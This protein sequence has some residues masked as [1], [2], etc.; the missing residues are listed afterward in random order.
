MSNPSRSRQPTRSR[1]ADIAGPTSPPNAR[2]S[3]ERRAGVAVGVEERA[4]GRVLGDRGDQALELTRRARRDGRRAAQHRE[5]DR[6]AAT[7][8]QRP[9]CASRSPTGSIADPVKRMCWKIICEWCSRQRVRYATS[10]SSDSASASTACSSRCVLIAAGLNVSSHSFSCSRQTLC[11]QTSSARA[12]RCGISS[13]GAGR[14]KWYAKPLTYCRLQRVE[15]SAV[16]RHELVRAPA[17]R[18]GMHLRPVPRHRTREMHR[19][20]APRP[21][22]G[23]FEH[24]PCRCFS[25]HR[26]GLPKSFAGRPAAA[27]TDSHR[28]NRDQQACI[29]PTARGSGGE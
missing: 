3:R 23:R 15:R 11:S 18:L 1:Y 7:S 20:Q 25:G 22:S 12:K 29:R 10:S 24:E 5:R 21:R 27:R 4:G 26:P 9:R 28:A 14:V 8:V 13:S 6:L 2:S 16:E 19:V 17:E